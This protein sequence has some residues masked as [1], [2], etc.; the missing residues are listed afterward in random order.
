MRILHFL[1]VY[2]PA[3]QYG[4][5]VLSVSR[6]CEGLA[7]SGVDVR[8]V[9]TNAGLPKLPSDALG[10]QQIINGVEVIYYPVDKHSGTIRS[11]SL[12][13]ALYEHMEWAELLHTSSIWQPL[14]LPVQKVAH[15]L[16][17]PVIQTLRGA[18][19]PYSWKRSWLKKAPYFF[20]K[21][22]PMLQRSAAIHCT[23]AQEA[24]EISWLG[25]RPPV[26]LLPNP[27][28]LSSFRCDQSLGLQWR[29]ML[30]IPLDVPLL[31]VA[32][33]FHHKK[34]L[35]LLPSI[36]QQLSD[37]SW[38]ILL[39]GDDDDGT[40]PQLKRAIDQLCLSNRVHW[41]DYLPSNELIGPFNAADWLLLPSH[42]ENFGNVV[43]EALACGCGAL[44]S[45]TVGVSD[46]IKDC[47][48]VRVL[49]RDQRTWTK[50]LQQTL[51]LK[52]PGIL[53]ENFIHHIFSSELIA[54]QAINLYDS[55]LGHDK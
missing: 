27:I 2:A 23:T 47:P 10:K 16:G 25:L 6:L 32:G 28:D 36:L 55:L 39:I 4:G 50:V 30:E 20:F 5:P 46:L 26:I 14:G 48:G 24:N 35:D 49:P 38:H 15:Q 13:K 22:K 40:K 45:D 42:H 54:S 12:V 33:R 1:P 7:E 31:L 52:R 17:V 8:V 19:G 43:T 53:S 3:W 21:E 51:P 37:E 44:I 18:L 9:T 34:G 11:R 29:K 41:Y